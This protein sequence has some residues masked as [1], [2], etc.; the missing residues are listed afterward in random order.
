MSF[1]LIGNKYGGRLINL[2]L[3]PQ[4][5]TIISA[6]VGNDISFDMKLINIKNCNV[7]GIDPTKKSRDFIKRKKPTNFTF[8][9]KALSHNCKPTL[10]YKNKLFIG[11]TKLC[12]IIS[13]PV[14]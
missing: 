7:I 13:V 5:S 8:I 14:P 2:D 1:E 12:N 3:V 4:N 6:G 10:L 9:N 11:D